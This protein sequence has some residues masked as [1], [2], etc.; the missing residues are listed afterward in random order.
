MIEKGRIYR[1]YKG[2]LYRILWVGLNSDTEQ[3]TVVY[4][5]IDTETAYQDVDN[6]DKIWTRDLE[7]FDGETEIDGQNVKRFTLVA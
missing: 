4:Q 1:H 2:G 3:K 6:P 7:V 5:N